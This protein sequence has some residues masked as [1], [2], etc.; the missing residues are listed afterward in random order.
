MVVAFCILAAFAF[1]LTGVCLWLFHTLT[2]ER[3]VAAAQK[4]AQTVFAP[5]TAMPG[6]GSAPPFGGPA[7]TYEDMQALA[8]AD[9]DATTRKADSDRYLEEMR[10]EFPELAYAIAQ[11][12]EPNAQ[13]PRYE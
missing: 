7:L 9:T 5:S 11:E 10:A 2:L 6:I 1:C 13:T 12:K 3:A 8:E 4:P